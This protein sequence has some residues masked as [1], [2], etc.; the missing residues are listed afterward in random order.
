MSLGLISL[1][2]VSPIPK[3]PP[4]LLAPPPPMKP[5]DR[6]IVQKRKPNRSSVGRIPIMLD[7]E[8]EEKLFSAATVH[9]YK[10]LQSANKKHH[11][12]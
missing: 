7:L 10:Y 12:N 2:V 4:P 9:Y 1:A 8:G 11:A 5:A 6:R 3:M